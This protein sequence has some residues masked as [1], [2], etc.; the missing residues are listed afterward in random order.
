MLAKRTKLFDQLLTEY[1][2]SRDE[3][4]TLLKRKQVL[5]EEEILMNAN[6]QK[7][8]LIKTKIATF[9][10]QNQQLCVQIEEARKKS[11]TS[12]NQLK[13]EEEAKIRKL[14]EEI[15]DLERR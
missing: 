6:K 9:R 15:H 4:A 11:E 5:V 2:T 3:L 12:L 1:Q 8:D 10:D 7:L 14:S 13:E